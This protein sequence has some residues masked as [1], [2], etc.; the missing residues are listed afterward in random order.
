[1]K[2]YVTLTGIIFGLITLA[3]VLRVI[4][5]G[6]RVLNVWWILITIVT[7]GM[8]IWAFRLVRLSKSS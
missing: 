2:T 3:H 8:S 4:Q 1:M 5:E 7:A 6:P